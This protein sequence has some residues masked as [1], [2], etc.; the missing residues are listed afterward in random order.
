[1]SSSEIAELCRNFAKLNVITLGRTRLEAYDRC[2]ELSLAFEF[3]CFGC[4]LKKSECRI[5]RL[6]HPIKPFKPLKQA[7]GSDPQYHHLISHYVVTFPKMR[8]HVDWTARQFWPS[9][10]HPWIMDD[11]DLVTHWGVIDP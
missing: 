6:E 9:K 2:H 10:P 4:G 8:L 3:F 11:T 1:M 5:M 7:G